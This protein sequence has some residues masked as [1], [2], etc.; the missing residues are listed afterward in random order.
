LKKEARGNEINISS[1]VQEDSL[2]PLQQ[3]TKSREVCENFISYEEM[4]KVSGK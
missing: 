1:D 4:F 3:P 2:V